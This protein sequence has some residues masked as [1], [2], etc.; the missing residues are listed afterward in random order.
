MLVQH[1]DKLV[2][3][4]RLAA[5]A[6]WWLPHEKICWVSERH[7]ILNRDDHGRLHS[8]T[9]PALAYPDGWGIW[10]VHGVRVPQYIIEQPQQI[11][12][13]K[14]GGEANAEIRRVMIDR[15]GAAKFLLDSG[16]REIS[17]DDWGTLYRKPVPN[18]EPLV[19]VK[20][21]NAT[22]EPDGTFKDYF[23]RVPPQITTAR[24]AVA[25]TFGMD[26]KEYEPE[27]QT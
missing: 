9:G 15:Y 21:V 13:A 6:G 11:T 16:A 3:L 14:I 24:S 5:C 4:M 8:L 20:V 2:P 19:M 22:P 1:T 12:V 10:A 7:N 27:L 18:D 25:W 23:L 26:A 17:R